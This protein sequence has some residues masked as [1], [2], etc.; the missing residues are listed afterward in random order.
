MMENEMHV[1]RLQQILPP[2]CRLHQVFTS[3]KSTVSSFFFEFVLN[4]RYRLARLHFDN[5]FK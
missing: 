2:K 4:P 5:V 3:E 1:S